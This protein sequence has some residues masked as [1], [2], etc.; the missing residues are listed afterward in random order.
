ME[1]VDKGCLMIRMGVSGYQPTWVVPD[2][3]CQTVVCVSVCT[4]LVHKSTASINL[5]V[6]SI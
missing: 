2:K 3:G 1:E 5:S 4:S 6:L